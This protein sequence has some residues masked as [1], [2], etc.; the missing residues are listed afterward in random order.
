MYFFFKYFLFYLLEFTVYNANFWRPKR[1]T[2][3]AERNIIHRP[4]P[5]KSSN[6][7]GIN[8]KTN[9]DSD[10]CLRDV[11]RDILL[12]VALG[13]SYEYES[14]PLFE[15]LYKG[16]FENRIY[17]GPSQ[18]S[19]ETD[20]KIDI[21]DTRNGG[22]LYECLT[23]TLR[24]YPN[25]TGYIFT[26]EEILFNYWKFSDYDKTRIWQDTSVEKGPA[27]YSQTWDDWEW[28]ASPW[29]M[30]ALE[31]SYEYIV[32]RNYGNN[33]KSKLSQGE[34]QPEWD[35]NNALNSWLWN[36]KG[37]Y[38]AY[39]INRTILYLPQHYAETF[40]HLARIF[41]SSGV[42]HAI[43]M[44]TI[45][46]L[47]DLDSRSLKLKGD[48]I[49]KDNSSSSLISDRTLLMNASESYDFMYVRGG[50]RERRVILND[51]KLKEFAMGKFL[52]YDKCPITEE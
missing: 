48:L 43:A 27:I 13:M 32:E 23:Y 4:P 42:R 3:V 7:I 2:F 19:N 51:L 41:R 40:L 22:F 38:H 8:T 9:N 24:T 29:G 25:Y 10:F 52:L 6:S 50:R 11:F 30:R 15:L 31:K 26:A 39:W 5:P 14:I 28:W 18:I 49:N 20:F 46:R 1:A 44:P 21:V 33:R 34:W 36:G 45:M 35:T 47:L 17:C 12:V 16:G 37:D